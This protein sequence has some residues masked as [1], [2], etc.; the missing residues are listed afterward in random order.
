[1]LSLVTGDK[2]VLI[3]LTS[4]HVCLSLLYNELCE[5]CYMYSMTSILSSLIVFMESI[6]VI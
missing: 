3:S 5:H 1:M 6:L 4:L 2:K